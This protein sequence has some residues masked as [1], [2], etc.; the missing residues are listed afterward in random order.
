MSH[1]LLLLSPQIVHILGGRVANLVEKWE[2]NKVNYIV[3][4]KYAKYRFLK[5]Y[6]IPILY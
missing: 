1:G 6:F 5:F 3:F 2:L 4:N